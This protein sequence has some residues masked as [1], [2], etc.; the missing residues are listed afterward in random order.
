[1]QSVKKFANELVAATSKAAQVNKYNQALDDEVPN[2]KGLSLPSSDPIVGKNCRLELLEKHHEND[3]AKILNDKINTSQY[4]RY[5]HGH[6]QKD[7]QQ[8]NEVNEFLFKIPSDFEYPVRISFVIIFDEAVKGIAEFR[9]VVP[10][11][12][13]LGISIICASKDSNIA[14]ESGLLL[15]ERAFSS[16]YRRCE[17]RCNAFDEY[18]IDLALKLGLNFESV[19]RCA[20]V[21][22]GHNVDDVIF[23]ITD[24][25]WQERSANESEATAY[26]ESEKKKIKARLNELNIEAR[27]VDENGLKMGYPVPNWTPRPSPKEGLLKGRLCR[28]EILEHRHAEDLFNVYH[29]SADD[30]DWTYLHASRPDSVES[31]K[32]WFDSMSAAPN[33]VSVAIICNKTNKPVG[34]AAFLRIDQENG[35]LEIGSIN[36]S[37]LLQRTIMGTEAVYLL[38]KTTFNLGY[39]RC[40]WRCDIF[41]ERSKV[42]AYRYGFT[43]EGILKQDVVIKNRNYDVA[44]FSI[45]DKEWPKI[46]SAISKWL[47]PTNFDKD[48]KQL[49]RLD[50]YMQNS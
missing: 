44:S 10:H 5:F 8:I 20:R 29:Q 43:F 42:A 14:Q 40:M 2:W 31:C 38:M 16:G 49:K 6:F 15:L 3:L 27:D 13:C 35:V 22:N 37:H 28:F 47:N 34:T 12:G 45:V 36:Y 25:Q 11:F 1:M 33:R 41:N 23:G 46:D 48:G 26:I 39:R 18:S 24:K 4:W 32:K 9:K 50:E 17:W 30:R 21:R 19:L 7:V